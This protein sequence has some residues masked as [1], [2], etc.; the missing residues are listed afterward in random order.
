MNDLCALIPSMAPLRVCD[1]MAPCIL[2]THGGP[3]QTPSESALGTEVAL[4][5][6]CS[7]LSSPPVALQPHQ[8]PLYFQ[9]A[10]AQ[11]DLD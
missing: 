5:W 4:E 8:N 1:C 6:H 7:A 2:V 3:V 11:H 9:L 10:Q